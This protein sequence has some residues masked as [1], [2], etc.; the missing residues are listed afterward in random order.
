MVPLMRSSVLFLVFSLCAVEVSLAQEVE[1][2]VPPDDV[3]PIIEDR[4][5]KSDLHEAYERAKA[6]L[7]AE[8]VSFS[9]E[10]VDDL[11]MRKRLQAEMDKLYAD[12]EA[13]DEAMYWGELRTSLCK[14]C[15]GE[16]GNS[17]REGIPS[18][19]GQNPVYL[20]DQ[21][22]RY[23]DDRRQDYWMASLAKVIKLED[24]IKLAIYYS[25]Q[26]M[27][28]AGGGAPASLERG[29]TLYQELCTECHGEDAKGPEGYARL[30]GQRPEYT[31]KM[32]V[33]FAKG[34]GRRYNPWMYGRANL[35]NN[36]QDRL[37]LATYL[38][39]LE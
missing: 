38:A 20:V 13:L 35:V 16:D 7:E 26:Q 1:I 21:F 33:E 18:L 17:S 29:K 28:P 30:A 27:K 8:G 24:K 34:D 9:E 19:A 32:L 11:T 39:H 37:A 4:Q 2:P 31:V 5:T 23:G 6:Q 3:A 25:R 10:H 14:E 12:P 22:Q 15:H 36:D